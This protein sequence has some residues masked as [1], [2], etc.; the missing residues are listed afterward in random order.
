MGPALCCATRKMFFNYSNITPY[1]HV[2]RG[3]FCP[4]RFACRFRASKKANAATRRRG[5]AAAVAATSLDG[6]VHADAVLVPRRLPRQGGSE[7]EILE[8]ICGSSAGAEAV[9]ADAGEAG[10]VPGLPRRPELG[11]AGGIDGVT[12]DCLLYTSPSPRDA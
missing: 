9:R 6:V 3:F 12:V 10:E 2:T 5:M 4:A 1:R 8:G 7:P 11:C